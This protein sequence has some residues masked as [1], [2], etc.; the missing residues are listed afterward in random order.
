MPDQIPVIRIS[1]DHDLYVTGPTTEE[2]ADLWGGEVKFEDAAECALDFINDAMGEEL[3]IEVPWQ[4]EA[5]FGCGETIIE[6]D[7]NN[8]PEARTEFEKKMSEAI[9]KKLAT[10]YRIDLKKV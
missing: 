10:K 5:R 8:W 2:I 1:E 6:V 4:Y 3:P 7:H 9:I